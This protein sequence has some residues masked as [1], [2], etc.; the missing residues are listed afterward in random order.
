[1]KRWWRLGAMVLLFSGPLFCLAH[2]AQSGDPT[3]DPHT[4]QELRAALS[5]KIAQPFAPEVA[6]E[7]ATQCDNAGIDEAEICALRHEA[8]AYSCD[9]KFVACVYA[10]DGRILSSNMSQGAFPVRSGESWTVKVVGPERCADD[11]A[12]TDR[13]AKSSWSVSETRA[14]WR[15]NMASILGTGRAAP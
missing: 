5:S 3:P 2:P 12:F 15:G 6:N 1:M 8:L 13:T 10:C 9:Q 4:Y 11:F 7:V 14:T